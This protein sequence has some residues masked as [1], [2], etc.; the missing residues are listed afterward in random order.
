[1][2]SN[3]QQLR[4]QLSRLRQH[5]FRPRRLLAHQQRLLELQQLRDLVDARRV[6]RRVRDQCGDLLVQCRCGGDNLRRTRVTREHRLELFERRRDGRLP[7]AEHSC[8]RARMVR[9]QRQQPRGCRGRH[10]E[11][12]DQWDGG[13]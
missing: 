10:C 2:C 13:Q 6:L 1:M 12:A 8:M 4:S 11:R 9:R 7:L 5:Q 3:G